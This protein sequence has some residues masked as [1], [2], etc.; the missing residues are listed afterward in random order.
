V[1][2]DPV[3]FCGGACGSANSNSHQIFIFLPLPPSPCP[4]MRITCRSVQPGWGTGPNHGWSMAGF[5]VPLLGCPIGVSVSE[6]YIGRYADRSGEGKRRLRPD[7]RLVV[8]RAV[9]M[10]WPS[11]D[12]PL[13]LQGV[14]AVKSSAHLLTHR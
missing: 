8:V 12:L 7:L 3:L 5:N 14:E 13:P 6:G 4:M 10:L 9:T 11:K 2:V 1:V